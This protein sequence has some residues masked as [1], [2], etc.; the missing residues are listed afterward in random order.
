[1]QPGWSFLGATHS[2]GLN[3]AVSGE[4]NN[5]FIEVSHGLRPGP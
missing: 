1:M 4:G 5:T 3:L 2:F